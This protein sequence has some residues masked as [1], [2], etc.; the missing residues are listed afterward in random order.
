MTEKTGKAVVRWGI[1]GCGGIAR[2]MAAVI[3]RTAGGQ[4]EAVASRDGERAR[5]FAAD[6]G[7][8]KAYEGY[9]ALLA[10]GDVD[11]MYVAAIHPGAR[12]VGAGMPAGREAGAL[13][14]AA[15]HDGGGGGIAVPAGR[16]NGAAADG[17]D[18]EPVSSRLPGSKGVCGEWRSGR[19]AGRVHRF[20]QLFCL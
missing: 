3:G 17:G 16:G 20:L 5:A 1:L 11:A 10:D 9:D 7:A 8:P 6:F 18:V 13:R 2:R 19:S 4:L 14:K 12:R 15:D